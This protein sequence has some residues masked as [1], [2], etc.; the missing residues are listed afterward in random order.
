MS[1]TK[2]QVPVL[3]AHVPSRATFDEGQVI[4][5]ESPE[6][7]EE[8]FRFDTGS[9]LISRHYVQRQL[10]PMLSRMRATFGGAER[11]GTTVFRERCDVV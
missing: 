8:N 9:A 11:D 1:T 5:F 2:R 6:V 3:S 7:L 10:N 4:H